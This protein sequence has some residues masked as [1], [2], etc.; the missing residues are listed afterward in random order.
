[1]GR[2]LKW[3][4]IILPLC[5][6]VTQAA[7]TSW[8]GICKDIPA[9]STA[10][11]LTEYI[12]PQNNRI[13]LLVNS[14]PILNCATVELP[15]SEEKITA[16]K[17]VSPNLEAGLQSGFSLSGMVVD[18]QFQINAIIPPE[19]K[20]SV[21]P[22]PLDVELG[23]QIKTITFGI[24]DRAI[25]SATGAVT[26][27]CRPGKNAAGII[28]SLPMK[29]LSGSFPLSISL[30]YNADSDFEFGISDTLR[31]AK[32]DPLPVAKLHSNTK[33]IKIDI[34]DSNLN[35]D[36]IETFTISCPNITSKFALTSLKF[37]PK[38]SRPVAPE[39]SFWVWQAQEWIQSPDSLLNKLNKNNIATLF[40]N[41]PIDLKQKT[42]LHKKELQVFINAATRQK[43]KIF[44]VVGDPGAVLENQRNVYTRYP[45][46]YL[47]YNKSVSRSSRLAGIQFDIEPY[48]NAGYALDPQTW[49]AA[50][51]DTLWQLKQK[52][53]LPIDVA[54]PYWWADEQIF[55][56]SLMDQLADKVDSVTVMNYRTRLDQ[57]KT[58]A[59][60]F[61]EWGMRNHHTVKIAL[62]SGPIS[63]E[64]M[65]Q[66]L[67]DAK[68]E[69][70]LI[71]IH[72]HRVLLK[73]DQVLSFPEPIT[74]VQYFHYSGESTVGGNATT[75][76][77]QRDVL[78]EI[79]PEL[80]TL[81]ENWTSFSGIA[82][83]EFKL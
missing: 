63:D 77:G 71:K 1:M 43:I 23:D 83:H 56:V 51:L 21:K 66:Y 49:Y 30:A 3:S 2:H 35:L 39:R 13:Q 74:H 76:S 19:G 25:A 60:P 58:N 78:L 33:N 7:A 15:V 27:E 54:V 67:P 65:Q 32:G 64:I 57:I 4:W 9:A 29:G 37:I 6:S 81:W 48:L 18:N 20:V 52:S 62:E 45:E 31:V 53:L 72:S 16:G 38:V 73:F 10:R 41:V 47:K 44:A 11:V 68:G 82:L 75:F 12:T 22:Y 79:L 5:L 50:Y 40:L 42:V 34:P 28:L 26:L 36:Q 69:L 80:E 55:G 24:E 46:A 8:L 17:F 14:V 61:L 59:Q 70:A